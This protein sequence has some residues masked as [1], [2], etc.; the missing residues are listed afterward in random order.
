PLGT[1]TGAGLDLWKVGDATAQ[2]LTTDGAT[3]FSGWFDGRIVASRLSPGASAAAA[4]SAAPVGTAG[5]EGGTTAS[6]EP[7]PG[8]SAAVP[9]PD[10]LHP[11]SFLLDPATLLTTDLAGPDIWLPAID[12]TGRFVAY[13]SG[14]VILDPAGA[15][16]KPAT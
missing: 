3:Y 11:T 13:W 5:A 10:E 1:S 16:W 7:S 14:T 2:P 9:G 15:G 12:P 4:E 8:Q 6:T